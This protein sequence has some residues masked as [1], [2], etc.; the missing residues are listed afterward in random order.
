MAIF[1]P[2]SGCPP[3]SLQS[4]SLFIFHIHMKYSVQWNA[5][6][7]V[8]LSTIISNNS[9]FF[10]E[11][12]ECVVTS[13]T[14]KTHNNIEHKNLEATV[15]MIRSIL[16]NPRVYTNKNLELRNVMDVGTKLEA[17]FLDLNGRVLYLCPEDRGLYW[18]FSV[19][20]MSNAIC[21]LFFLTHFFVN[22]IEGFLAC[23]DDLPTDSYYP[24][25]WVLTCV[26]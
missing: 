22:V 2:L 20:V 4:S 15:Q 23:T 3:P 7:Q 18:P 13:G 26:P 17:T 25:H 24:V 10:W 16:C 21:S 12:N 11:G 8:N 5:Y 6:L 14:Y 1:S 19:C 9:I